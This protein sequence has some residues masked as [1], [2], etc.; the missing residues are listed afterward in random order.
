M[1]AFNRNHDYARRLIAEGYFQDPMLC[2][3]L[4]YQPPIRLGLYAE[5]PRLES[6]LDY[7][8]VFHCTMPVIH[9][10]RSVLRYCD[11]V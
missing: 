3:S 8:R 11:L 5:R 2:K 10:P 1:I 7:F 6:R 4:G 9:D